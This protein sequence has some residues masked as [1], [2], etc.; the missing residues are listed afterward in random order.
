MAEEAMPPLRLR[1]ARI[2]IRNRVGWRDDGQTWR[3]VEKN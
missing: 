3:G 1:G 2:I